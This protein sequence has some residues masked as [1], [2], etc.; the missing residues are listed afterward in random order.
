MVWSL[1]ITGPA[2]AGQPRMQQEQSSYRNVGKGRPTALLEIE[3][4]R[5]N[6]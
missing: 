4:E 3:E 1:H 6:R 2:V 5:N